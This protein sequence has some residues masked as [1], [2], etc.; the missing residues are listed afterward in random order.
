MVRFLLFSVVDSP[1]SA[2]GGWFGREGVVGGDVGGEGFEGV[3]E[4]GVLVCRVFRGGN[5]RETMVDFSPGEIL[6]FLCLLGAPHT[7]EEGSTVVGWASER[8]R[9]VKIATRV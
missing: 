4:H 7:R 9:V 6:V 3:C 2:V 5:S 1:W 8:V